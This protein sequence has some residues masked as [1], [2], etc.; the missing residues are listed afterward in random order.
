MIEYG[1]TLR[2]LLEEDAHELMMLDNLLDPDL[3]TAPDG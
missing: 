3:G 1:Y 2:E